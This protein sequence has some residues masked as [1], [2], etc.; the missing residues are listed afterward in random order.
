MAGSATTTHTYAKA[1]P[2]TV[3][4]VTSDGETA[5]CTV[6]FSA[7]AAP[8]GLAVSGTPTASEFDVAWTASPNADGYTAIATPPSGEAITGVVTGVTAKFTTGVAP[9]TTYKVAVTATDSTGSYVPS[10]PANVNVT[11]GMSKLA[12]PAGVAASG[13]LTATGFTA[14]WT[15]VPNAA[16]YTVTVSPTGP[17]LS[18]QEATSATFTGCDALT[19][20]TVSVV[21]TAPGYTS[22]DAGTG[23]VTTAATGTLAAPANVRAGTPA[24][25]A[26][27]FTATWDASPNATNYTVTTAPALGAPQIDP[28]NRTASFLGATGATAYT[29]SVVATAPGYTDSPAGTGTVTTA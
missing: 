17:T 4:T 10:P 22:S 16:A 29:V 14:A 2:G 8:T 26:T 18:E 25:T 6:P 3:A 20:Y 27:A 15:A 21:A 12:T 9:G 13:S 11:S 1:A 28:V 7:L 23:V 5:T 24:P 19:A